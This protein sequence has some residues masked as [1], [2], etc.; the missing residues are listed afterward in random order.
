MQSL[1][2]MPVQPLDESILSLGRVAGGIEEVAT[3][4]DILEELYLPPEKL[5]K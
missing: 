1:T 2:G 3:Q 5:E 4:C